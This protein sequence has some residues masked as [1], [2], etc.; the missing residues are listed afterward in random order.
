MIRMR[1]IWWSTQAILLP[2]NFS[3]ILA[4]EIFIVNI[5]MQGN[6]RTAAATPFYEKKIDKN[7]GM[8]AQRTKFWGK[9]E[10]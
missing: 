2:R 4:N 8:E 1:V 5:L 10:T 6:E 9:D 3:C 7:T